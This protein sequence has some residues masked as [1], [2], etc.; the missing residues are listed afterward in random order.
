MQGVRP[1]TILA[2]PFA[3]IDSTGFQVLSLMTRVCFLWKQSLRQELRAAGS[4]GW[5]LGSH[6]CN[7]EG[8]RM[9]PMED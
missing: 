1:S 4:L 2:D 7:R 5:A 6:T 9:G 3:I 8:G